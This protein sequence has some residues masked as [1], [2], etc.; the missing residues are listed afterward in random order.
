[1]VRLD[2]LVPGEGVADKVGLVLV[3]DER[4]L[5]IDGVVAAEDRVVWTAV[6]IPVANM[7]IGDGALEERTQQGH[8]RRARGE[9][10]CL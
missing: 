1:M 2:K 10:V 4:G 8:M 7:S 5:E 9:D 3:E 6:S